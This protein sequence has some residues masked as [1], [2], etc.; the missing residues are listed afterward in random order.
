M[1][2]PLPLLALSVL[3]TCPFGSLQN[4]AAGAAL[5]DVVVPLGPFCTSSLEGGDWIVFAC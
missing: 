4:L 1:P 5:V 2:G 3:A